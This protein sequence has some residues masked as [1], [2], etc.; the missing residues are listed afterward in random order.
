MFSVNQV[1]HHHV[2]AQYAP[3]ANIPINFGSKDDCGDSF[4]Q[5]EEKKVDKSNNGK[6]DFSEAGKNFLKGLISPITAVIKHPIAT[7]GLV[8]GTI[9]ACSL[10]PV[11]GPALAVG[12]GAY[13][14]FQLGKG[15]FDVAKNCFDRNYDAAENSFNTVG[16][17]TIGTL[18]SALGIRQ[19][20]KVAQESKLMSK[21]NA[22]TLNTAQRAEIATNVNKAG[23]ISN[24]KDSL[25]LFTT[26]DGLKSVGFQFKKDVLKAR[27]NEFKALFDKSKWIKEKEIEIDRK[28]KSFEEKIK[29]FKQSAEGQRRAALSDEQ[30][31]AEVEV[32]YNDAFDR[33]GIPQEQRPTLEIVKNDANKCGSYNKGRHT[34]NFNPESYK[35]GVM[36]I[37]DVIMH[38]ATHCREALLRAGI[39]QDR[40]DSIVADELIGR[41]RNGESEEIIKGGGFL[42]ADMT[43]P[44]KMSTAMK[45]DFIQ[46]ARDNLY[47]KDSAIGEI[48]QNLDYQYSIR[49]YSSFKIEKLQNA[50][51]A[52]QSIIDKLKTL[53]KKHPD[54]TKQYSTEQEALEAL[55]GYS[56]AHNFRYNLFTNT[57][58]NRSGFSGVGAD[59][60]DV[61]PLTGDALARAEQSL[62]DQI[63]TVEGN[64]RT[65]GKFFG[66]SEAEFNQYQ[67][68]P[69]EVLAQ[70]NGNNYLIDKMTAKINDMR[71]SGTL[72]PEQEAYLT[73]VIEKA[74]IVIEYKTKGLEYY[75]KYTQM[76]NNPN[77]RELAATVKAM[78]NEL[79]ALKAKISQEEWQKVT[80][81]IKVLSIPEHT[82]IS[83]PNVAIYKILN[84]IDSKK[85]A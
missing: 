70:K 38:E 51:K 9:T 49:N 60:V 25:S 28:T 17:G 19:S 35:S 71:A 13:S 30:I 82:S 56:K 72:T 36:E 85:T 23:F 34:L 66:C 48:I 40:V 43:K 12:F 39:P 77:D 2:N 76:I 61:K 21:L 37:E 59:Y 22:T 4:T 65:S 31:K 1:N 8:A 41:I 53:M 11:L 52:G 78:G 63:A 58:I 3:K 62:V 10:V 44:P 32:L 29:E 80:K 50:E 18:L 45:E 5:V 74:K 7:I 67:F 26:K 24:L 75:K 20:A 83:V 46:F 69:E 79:N 6:F 33:L 64:G 81:I 73:K 55:V 16:E 54:F 14:L 84:S 57:K 47:N 27:F 15:C 42:G 68:S